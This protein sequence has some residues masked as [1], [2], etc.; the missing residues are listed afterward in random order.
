MRRWWWLVVALVA[1][2]QLLASAGFDRRIKIFDLVAKKEVH[3]PG[4]QPR[5]PAP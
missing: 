1:A 2:A 3:C 4:L 5:P